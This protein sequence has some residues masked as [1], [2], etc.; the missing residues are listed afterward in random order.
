MMFKKLFF[1]IG[2]GDE[3]KERIHGAL[4]VNKWFG[5]H[6]SIMAFQLDPSTVYNVRMTLRGGVMMDEFLKT[7]KEELEA[8]Q[9]ENI[10]IFKE[11]C[12]KLGI[13]VSEDQHQPNSAFL[14][15]VIGTRSELVEKHSKYCDLVV[16]AVPPTGTITGTFEA[17]VVKSGKPAIV[18]PRELKEFK[19][20]RV[21]VSL[22]GST[23]NSRALTNAI[24]ILK[25]AKEVHCI[26]A[27]HYLQDSMEETQGRI[28]NYLSMHGI[29]PTFE[30]VKTEGKIPGQVLT[31]AAKN[32]KFDLIVTGINEDSGFR[33][34]F[35]G[36]A[37]RYFLKNT[38][39]PV[40]M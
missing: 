27:Q 15:N 38:T 24:P 12:D 17:G 2:G 34:I 19:I 6:M 8:E 20:E 40:F 33:E 26:T 25:E 4:L 13:K 5:T 37:S 18:I 21:L 7:A 9:E 35:L 14:R 23:T 36:G 32:G 30:I 31:D 16:V 11:E 1:P 3:L 28:R 39:V 10:R 22:T 29:N